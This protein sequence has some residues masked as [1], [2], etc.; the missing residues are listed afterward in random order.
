MFRITSYSFER[1]GFSINRKTLSKRTLSKY[2]CL[3][4]FRC[5]CKYSRV[6]NEGESK[7]NRIHFLAE[8]IRHIPTT[9]ILYRFIIP[10]AFN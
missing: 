9:M 10:S 2:S 6:R 7:N 3:S 1:T 8:C 4:T 5:L